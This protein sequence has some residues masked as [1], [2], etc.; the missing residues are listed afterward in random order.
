MP[1]VHCKQNSY[2]VYVGRSEGKTYPEIYRN[3]ERCWGNPFVVGRDGGRGECCDM[4]E[5]LL[6]D[7]I[8]HKRI[9]LAELAA[10]HGKTLGCWCAPN[11]CHGEV[12]ERAAAWARN[13]IDTKGEV[14]TSARR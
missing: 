11:K 4:F 6:K 12:L 2:E 14:W 8:K 3:G 7:D 5:K 13:H 1:V 9:S 10:L